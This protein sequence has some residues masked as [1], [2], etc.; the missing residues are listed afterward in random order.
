MKHITNFNGWHK[1]NNLNESL[2]VTVQVGIVL[3]L[4]GIKGIIAL[5]RKVAQKL[6]EDVELEKAELN[7]LIDQIIEDIEAADKSG[8]SFSALER[9]L[10]AKVAEGE[11]TMA[12]DIVKVIKTLDK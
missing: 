11:I 6:G 1:S 12:K 10:K 8:K 4:L 2:I 9:E 5:V 3:G 7:H